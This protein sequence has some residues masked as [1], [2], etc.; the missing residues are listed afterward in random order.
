MLE[1]RNKKMYNNYG[2]RQF[3]CEF[4]FAELQRWRNLYSHI[5]DWKAG[6]VTCRH[7]KKTK[8]LKRGAIFI[9]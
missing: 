3:A 4:I 1:N 2:S 9:D 8:H 6:A 5:G 7:T